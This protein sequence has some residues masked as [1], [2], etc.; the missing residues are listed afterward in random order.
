MKIQEDIARH[1]KSVLVMITVFVLSIY[2]VLNLLS[3]Q[4]K[5]TRLEAIY[6]TQNYFALVTSIEA[7]DA[8]TSNTLRAYTKDQGI[9]T[10]SIEEKLPISFD[11][12]T[13]YIYKDLDNKW[14]IY[15]KPDA[16]ATL[17]PGS[18]EVILGIQKDQI[19]IDRLIEQTDL[20]RCEFLNIVDNC[21]GYKYES[22]KIRHEIYFKRDSNN[23][24][25]IRTTYEDGSLSTYIF[26]KVNDSEYKQAAEFFA[27]YKAE[28]EE[29]IKE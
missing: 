14:N 27:T 1:K 16:E 23:L 2:L 20:D 25:Y 10:F 3:R 7:D 15:L 29:D 8:Y 5:Y 26:S 22:D 24:A 21:L 19:Q 4:A 11:F 9:V 17:I 28:I 6:N 18:L 12:K 13:Q